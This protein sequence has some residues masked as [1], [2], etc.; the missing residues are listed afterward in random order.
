MSIVTVQELDNLKRN[1]RLG[2]QARTAIKNIEKANNVEIRVHSGFSGIDFLEHNNDNTILS[3][4]CDVFAFDKD[5]VFLTDDYALKVKADALELPCSMFE[6]DDRDIEVYNGIRELTLS[7]EEY[8]NLLENPKNNLYNL[9][10]NEYVIINNITKLDQYL[11]VWNSNY[12]EEVKVK[13]ISNKYLNK[14]NPLDI[15]QKAFIHMLQSDNIKIKI[16]EE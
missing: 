12:F 4:A 1:E 13:P 7:E 5:C 15:Y 3:C 14:I 10:P 11:L 6:F 2:Y 16:M 8:V 9:Y